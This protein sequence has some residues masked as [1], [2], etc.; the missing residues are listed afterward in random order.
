[1]V[2]KQQQKVLRRLADG[3]GDMGIVHNLNIGNQFH[4]GL[5][6]GRLLGPLKG[7]LNIAG[8]A[9]GA[10]GKL[11]VIRDLESEGTTIR[12]DLPGFCHA[13]DNLVGYGV[14]FHQ[15]LMGKDERHH[16]GIGVGALGVQG[17]DVVRYAD[18]D[19]IL[20]G[21]VAARGRGIGAS[22]GT[23]GVAG[24]RR[25]SSVLGILSFA[26]KEASH[27]DQA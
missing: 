18:G 23:F 4:L 13:G 11:Y 12:G 17:G 20:I 19:G 24:G 9:G 27:H 5:G 15:G 14:Y 2:G 1:M 6:E 8:G 25:R 26:A 7:E 10:V 3:D 16:V 21:C 22:S